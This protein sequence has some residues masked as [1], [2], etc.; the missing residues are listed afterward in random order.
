MSH[1]NTITIG[2]S[3]RSYNIPTVI[4]G[5][6]VSDD[7]AA[8]HFKKTGKH[9]G[10]FKKLEGALFGARER[11]KK[12]HKSTEPN[13]YRKTFGRVPTRKK[14]GFQFPSSRNK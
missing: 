7:E 12:G 3:G 10:S 14:A 8:R 9:F 4:R 6:Q 11:S 5:K 1:E 2:I 13:L